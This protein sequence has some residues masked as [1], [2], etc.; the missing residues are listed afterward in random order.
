MKTI[1][2]SDELYN[3]LVEAKLNYWRKK[4]KRVNFSDLLE[5][6]EI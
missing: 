2:I 4:G 1:R 5:V 6:K 3:K